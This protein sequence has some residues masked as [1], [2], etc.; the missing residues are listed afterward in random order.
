VL[1]AAGLEPPV[2]FVT[3]RRVTTAPSVARERPRRGVLDRAALPGPLTALAAAAAVGPLAASSGGYFSTSWG[4][5]VVPIAW[6]TAVALLVRPR[7][8][9]YR[10]EVVFFAAL[11]LL[12]GW[13]ALSLAWTADFPQTVLE[14]E[15]LLLYVVV[16]LAAFVLLR[17]QY[18]AWALAGTALACFGI[19][20]YA[21]ETR[22][23]PTSAGGATIGGSRLQG[24]IGYWNGLG[25]FAAMTALLVAGLAVRSTWRPGRPLAAAAVVIVLPTLYFTYSRGAWGALIAGLVV[26]FAVDPHRLR[27]SVSLLVIAPF[28]AGAVLV[29]ARSDALTQLD[30]PVREATADGHRAAL[31]V[32]LLAIG[33][34]AAI[35]LLEWLGGRRQ[36]G[37]GV[38]RAYAIVLVVVVLTAVS[39]ALA[40]YGGP[41]SAAK[42]A[43]HSFTGAPVQVGADTSLNARLFNLSSNGRL[44][45]WSAAWND[46]TAHPVLGSG[47]GTYETYWYRH[48]TD[49]QTVQ[50]AHSLYLE[51]LAEL[52][53]PGLA[54]LAIALSIPL[55]V[56]ARVRW[57]R[58]GPALAGAYVAYLVHAAVDWDWELSAVTVTALVSGLLL[59]VLARDGRAPLLRGVP[60][61]VLVGALLLPLAGFSLYTLIGNRRLADASEAAAAGDWRH[62]AAEARSAVDWLPWS[63]GAWHALAA[64]D[65]ARGL[66]RRAVVE[67]REAVERSPNQWSLWYDLGN[68][69]TGVERRQA[70]ARAREL[71]PREGV[72]PQR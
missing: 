41:V 10:L 36:P 23:F 18:V 68:V 28:A 5:A 3:L 47:A 6:I 4:W 1:P 52:G 42:R 57:S 71:D 34:A 59:I 7:I 11:V 8:P 53:L 46:F 37:P 61:A 31:V 55:V 12:T 72:I 43:Y 25:I 50:D 51:T 64:A 49:D 2:T 24:T 66:R 21:L 63:A 35:A 70:Y 48:R 65:A 16:A 15:R 45:L 67:M 17:R 19:C 22:L 26:L 39:V 30:R 40:A 9:V 62:A 60:R 20:A 38:R 27:S 29:C 44:H 14:V 32:V 56:L 58:Y 54:L 69:A 13:T 33:A